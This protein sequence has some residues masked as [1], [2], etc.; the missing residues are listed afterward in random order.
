MMQPPEERSTDDF[1]ETVV[2]GPEEASE[3]YELQKD[4]LVLHFA[5]ALRT[6]K[7]AGSP[8]DEDAINDYLQGTLSLDDHSLIFH[9]ELL[10]AQ[11]IS[12]FQKR[13]LA[14]TGMRIIPAAQDGTP[15]LDQV[16]AII[17][18]DDATPKLKMVT[19]L[20][21]RSGMPTIEKAATMLFHEVLA[22]AAESFSIDQ[23]QVAFSGIYDGIDITLQTEFAQS[24]GFGRILIA[25]SESLRLSP[26]VA[27]DRFET[28]SD[29]PVFEGAETG[30]MKLFPF[31]TAGYSQLPKL[32]ELE[33]LKIIR[34]GDDIWKGQP[35]IT[36]K[37]V[38]VGIVDDGFE[39]SHPDL[40]IVAG[41]NFD[42]SGRNPG[43]A[44]WGP[45]P[46]SGHGTMIAGLIG[47]KRQTGHHRDVVGVAPECELFVASVGPGA[48]QSEVAEAI[49]WLVTACEVRVLNLSL[50]TTASSPLT[51]AIDAAV[52]DYDVVV[53]A[54]AG[55]AGA[56]YCNQGN[57]NDLCPQGV[58]YP[59]ALPQVISVGATANRWGERKN[60]KTADKELW[61]SQWSANQ[62]DV[63]APGVKL[64]T[65]DEIGPAG[66]TKTGELQEHNSAPAQPSGTID[67]DYYALAGGTSGATALV[68]GLAALI[69]SIPG[70]QIDAR[71]TR[72]IIEA[73]CQK[74]LDRSAGTALKI[75]KGYDYL[76][77]TSD[78][79]KRRSK[80]TGYGLIDCKAALKMAQK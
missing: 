29:S 27:L 72:A 74:V 34:L 10:K 45:H 30:W 50:H 47:S 69:R 65:T 63:V 19:P 46:Y 33:Y 12:E 22:V 67:G 68:S 20:Y 17:S 78:P 56:Y 32:E 51:K 76:P 58:D 79:G 31:G 41:R 3:V 28:L 53:C 49:S 54:A 39:K 26:G 62:L 8:F 59:A 75:T 77:V 11:H 16:E 18:S 40:N 44:N 60:C 6:N 14:A 25:R 36:G 5:E 57:G 64:W 52:R 13:T 37:G 73:T 80:A 70:K 24:H 2:L 42:I 21:N 66:L 23:A 35:P 4:V 43:E 9:D 48:D 1:P 61:Q 7:D 55:N 38:K 15:L 71:T